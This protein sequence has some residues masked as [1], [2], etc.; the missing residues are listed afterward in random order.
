MKNLLIFIFTFIAGFGSLQ[1]QTAEEIVRTA[2][3]RLRGKSSESEMKVTIVR[4]KYTREM[5]I[6]SWSYQD[7]YS[8]ILI[9][10]PS[11]DAGTTFLRRG[12][13]IWNWIPSIERTIKMPPS[14]MS[15][16]W[17]GTDLTNDDLVRESSIIRDYNHSIIGE[18]QID[19]RLCWKIEMIPTEEAAVEWGRVLVWIDQEHYMQMKAEYYDEDEFLVNTMLGK[20]PRLFGETMLPGTMEVIPADKEGHKTV[21]E[22][23]EMT[24]D[25][26]I[27]ESFFSQQRMRTVGQ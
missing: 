21:M 12:K 15:Q 5:V 24:F 2:D 9:K 25:I 11:K 4:P 1:A 6:H 19:G 3:Q 8:L 17:M 26:E 16:N 10:S 13:E 23:I 7:E 18:E 14:M 22:Q 20:N 27:N